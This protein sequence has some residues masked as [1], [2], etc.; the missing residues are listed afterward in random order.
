MSGRTLYDLPRWV[1]AIGPVVILL[2]VFAVLF[3]TS[4]FGDLS[5]VDEASTLEI[6]WMLTIIGAIAGIIPVAIGMLWFPF[7]RDLDPRYL[8]A[9]L[10]LAAGVLAFIAVEMTEDMIFDYGLEAE[11]TMLAATLAIVGVGGTF[12]IMYAASQWRQR[13]M[14]TS[15]KSGLE[16]AYLVA[17]ALGLHS[18][19]EGLGIGVAYING[20]ATLLMLLVL[21]F[22]MHNVMEGPTVVAAVARDRATPPLRHFA[23]MGLIAGGPVILGGYIGSFAQSNLLAVL[24]FAIAIGAILQVLIEVAELIRFDAEAVL[25]RTNAAT[26]TVGFA[27][28][29]LLEDVLTDVVLE[30]W[31]VPA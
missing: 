4:P 29:F 10:A 20:D 14:S 17:L 11:N 18:I 25:T 30:G 24:F 3:L 2:A 9:F 19:G 13:K 26:F 23:A 7:I 28:M 21:A 16:I 1:L 8:H 22:V 5:A 31:L 6:V 15:E 12:A 27:L